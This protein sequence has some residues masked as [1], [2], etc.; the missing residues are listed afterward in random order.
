MRRYDD[1]PEPGLSPPEGRAAEVCS[2]CGGDIYE[3]ESYGQRGGKFYCTDCLEEEFRRLPEERKI[4][5][6]G[7]TVYGPD[8]ARDVFGGGH[9]E[10]IV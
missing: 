2:G 10:R 9:G 4:A 8:T 3:G 1:C 7:C 5:V 6:M